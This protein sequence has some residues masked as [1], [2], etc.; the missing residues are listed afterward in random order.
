MSKVSGHRC[1]GGDESNANLS[2]S[3]SFAFPFRVE[4]E[5]REIYGC[6]RLHLYP[7][8]LVP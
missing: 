7:T 4:V 2:L 8:V 6:L 1:R 3:P 5:A